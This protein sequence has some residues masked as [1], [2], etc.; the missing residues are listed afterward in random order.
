MYLSI[1]VFTKITVTITIFWGCR[2]YCIVATLWVTFWKNTVS[3]REPETLINHYPI[4]RWKKQNPILRNM[5]QGS[6]YELT[7]FETSQHMTLNIFKC[8]LF[9]DE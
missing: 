2:Y 5:C 6:D 8:R 1:D 4:T 9:I 7:S 3:H